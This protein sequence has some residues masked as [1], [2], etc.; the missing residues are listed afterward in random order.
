MRG[1]QGSVPVS[2]VCKSVM[3]HGASGPV[4][5]RSAA[6]TYTAHC[7]ALLAQHGAASW[8]TTPSHQ[9]WSCHEVCLLKLPL[10]LCGM[11]CLASGPLLC[12]T[13]LSAI[14]THRKAMLLMLWDVCI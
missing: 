9:V 6:C 10:G 8:G 2:D 3:T 5:S 11:L 12:G 7:G 4:G 1:L 13:D 14:P